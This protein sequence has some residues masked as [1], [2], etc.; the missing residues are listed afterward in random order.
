MK[1]FKIGGVP[2]HFNLPWRLCIE[3]NVFKDLG[4]ELHWS[5]MTGGTGQMIKGL[6]SK[7]LDIAVLLTEGITQAILKG[8]QAK[9]IDIYVNSP[10]QWGIHI[11]V[12]SNVAE[13]KGLHSANFAVSRMGSGSHLMAYVLG[14]KFN[15]AMENI[16][17]NVIGDVYGGIWALEN[18]VSDAFLWEKYTTQPFVD[19]G[20]CKFLGQIDT[21]WPCFVVAGRNDVVEK[22]GGEIHEMLNRVQQ[23][24][25]KL[26]DDT[27]SVQEIAWRYHLQ[28]PSVE[29]WLKETE[30]K[31]SEAPYKEKLASVVAFLLATELITETEQSNWAQKLF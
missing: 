8:T 27:H 7:S 13:E 2:E 17:F 9:I 29:Q 18:H 23:R 24:A 10:L 5:D 22:Y 14:K 15:F 21:P 26:K 12:D 30:W 16:S 31:Y 3:E 19:K 20:S 4:I 28:E 25:K 6:E 1:R 11:P